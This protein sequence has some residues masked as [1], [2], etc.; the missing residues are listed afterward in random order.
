[1]SPQSFQLVMRSGPN[2]EKTFPLDKSEITIGRDSMNDIVINDAE[3][4]RKH[5]RLLLQPGGYMLEDLGST[6]GT[7]IEGQRLLGPHSLRPGEMIQFGETVTLNFESVEYDPDATY[8][9]SPATEFSSPGRLPEAEEPPPASP[10]YQSPSEPPPAP[11]YS[12]QI[13]S[14]PGVYEGQPAAPIR[15]KSGRNWIL[16]GC[17]CLL[18][19]LCFCVII[20]FIIDAQNLWCAPLLRPIT[21]VV[22]DLLNP[23]LD[24]A[25]ACP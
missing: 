13:P 9:S 2:P 17:G 21:N 14:G 20:I 11:A 7:F 12:G 1:M 4:S 3:V 24:G 19:T 22:F 8:V 18:I 15:K 16:A 5:A 25:L 10:E 23:F 6:N